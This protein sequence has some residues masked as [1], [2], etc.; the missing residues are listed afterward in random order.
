MKIDEVRG[1]TDAELEFDR[2]GLKKELFDLRFKGATETSAN[3]SRIGVARRA[4]ARIN[5]V[6]HERRKGIRGQESR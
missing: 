4:I 3:P 6:L 1:K 2:E 5:T